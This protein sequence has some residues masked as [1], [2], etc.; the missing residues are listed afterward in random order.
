MFGI[1]FAF[2]WG[3]KLA[4]ILL[5]S[6]PMFAIFGGGFGVAMQKGMTEYFKS[7]AQSAGYAE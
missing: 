4:A 2:T 6:F 5:G 3:W 1:I 7:Y